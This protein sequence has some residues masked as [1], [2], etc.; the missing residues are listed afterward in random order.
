MTSRTNVG[1]R[2]QDMPKFVNHLNP[3]SAIVAERDA[4]ISIE[5]VKM[6]RRAAPERT[7]HLPVRDGHD[8]CRTSGRDVKAPA[9]QNCLATGPRTGAAFGHLLR[10][11]VGTVGKV[12]EHF[13]LSPLQEHASTDGAKICAL[14]SSHAALPS[15]RL[16]S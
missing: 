10:Q 5:G 11:H 15:N 14:S 7:M 2:R 8:R 12:V 4:L 6:P 9:T 1:N 16:A 13:A 3:M